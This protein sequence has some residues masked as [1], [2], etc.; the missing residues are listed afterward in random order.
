MTGPSVE[1]AA[2]QGAPG[3]ASHETV[4]PG[5][6]GPRLPWVIAAVAALVAVVAV[7]GL[8]AV[9]P[10]GS[11]G[12]SSSTSAGFATPEEAIRQVA[13]TVAAGDLAG[14]AEA[15]AVGPIVE[16]Y[17]FEAEAER[18]RGV[19]PVGWLPA[20]DEGYRAIDTGL[21]QGQ[22]ALQLRQVVWQLT[23][24]ERDVWLATDVGA[25]LTAAELA[26]DLDPTELAGLQVERVDLLG[27]AGGAWA[28]YAA[29][30]AAI[31]GADDYQ[32]AAVLYRTPAGTRRGGA[33]L[34]E[35][36]GRWYV[37]SLQSYLSD[38]SSGT[39]EP[40]T[41]KEYASL[42]AEAQDRGSRA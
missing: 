13:E 21:R 39:L 31:Y 35:Y 23:A 37:W 29:E 26:A 20:E 28:Q 14:A 40:T 27:A 6:P 15:F 34:L 33:L 25:D 3:T 1:H 17:S 16:G 41:A 2:P 42:V 5:R 38:V 22:V 12:A 30:M 10:R 7:V 11:S 8:V 18:L 19:T 4:A 9:W 32:D 24:P 36:D